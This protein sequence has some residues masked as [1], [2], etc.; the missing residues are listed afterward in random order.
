MKKQLV[1]TVHSPQGGSGKSTIALNLALEFARK[2]MRVLLMDMAAYGGLPA[3]LKQPVRG[4]GMSSLI[5]IL[6]QSS[7]LPPFEHFS[8]YFRE[9]VTSPREQRDFHTLFSASPLKMESLSSEYAAYMIRAAQKENYQ[10]IVIDTSSE[11]CKRN[12]AC[13]EAA[14][15]LL[16][17]TLQDVASGWKIILFKEIAAS[18]NVAK[19]KIALVVNRCT[20]YSGFNNRELEAEIGYRLLG[21]IPDVTKIVQRGINAGVPMDLSEKRKAVVPFQQLAQKIL[22][23]GGTV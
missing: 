21:E 5:T 12:V 15:L 8:G 22:T 11:L 13:I 6:E 16:V 3:M 9:A 19:E 10:V 23:A 17:P 2:N 7:D 14:D 20:K 18:L 4:V 1:I